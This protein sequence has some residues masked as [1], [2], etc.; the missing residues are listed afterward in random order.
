MVVLDEIWFDVG[1]VVI[2][3]IGSYIIGLMI[4]VIG[5]LLMMKEML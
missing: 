5:L 3:G 2:E 1:G 4:V